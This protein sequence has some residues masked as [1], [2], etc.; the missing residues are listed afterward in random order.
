MD[1]LKD[2]LGQFEFALRCFESDL[3]SYEKQNNDY[4]EILDDLL[5]E[6]KAKYWE[7]EFETPQEIRVFLKKCSR[8]ALLD[9]IKF[10]LY[11]DI[12]ETLSSAID[13][14][15]FYSS[16]ESKEEVLSEV[17]S[18]C[19]SLEESWREADENLYKVF[20]DALDEV[21]HIMRPI[22]SSCEYVIE[23]K[24]KIN[25]MRKSENDSQKEKYIQNIQ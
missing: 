1:K 25:A 16:G 8:P 9:L 2:L 13:K 20:E 24:T 21:I 18:E 12:T 17:M 10:I 5:K 6:M 15:R 3:K 22:S 11:S 14:M 4:N 7:D 19:S 23:L